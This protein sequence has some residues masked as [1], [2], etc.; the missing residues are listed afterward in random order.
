MVVEAASGV[1]AEGRR[2]AGSAGSAVVIGVR[3]CDYDEVGRGCVARGEAGQG[4]GRTPTTNCW[5][6]EP[7]APVLCQD[8]G[9]RRCRH[10]C[11]GARSP[12][13]GEIQG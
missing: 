11:V 3:V 12:R 5:P 9:R 1:A 2:S 10:A 7:G 13:V 4:R 8:P 6:R